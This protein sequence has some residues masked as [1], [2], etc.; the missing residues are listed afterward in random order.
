MDG[1]HRFVCSMRVII[2]EYPFL[3]SANFKLVF[4]VSGWKC[5]LLFVTVWLESLCPFEVEQ[6]DGMLWRS[7]SGSYDF[8]FCKCHGLRLLSSFLYIS[9]S[10]K[11]RWEPVLWYA[12]RTW[13]WW[14]LLRWFVNLLVHISSL[15]KLR[16][17]R[18]HIPVRWWVSTLRTLL[19]EHRDSPWIG[20]QESVVE[21]KREPL[22][23]LPQITITIT[24]RDNRN[25][26]DE[27]DE[28]VM[29][30]NREF[31][32]SVYLKLQLEP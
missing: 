8:S 10:R 29:K 1:I 11:F 16:I 21:V 20:W 9:T 7:V 4:L 32:T 25:Q 18:L 26:P 14:L 23:G 15:L 27:T 28:H 24:N 2:L 31:K 22:K 3:N 13:V 19:L 30:P 6:G 17:C 12:S 5:P